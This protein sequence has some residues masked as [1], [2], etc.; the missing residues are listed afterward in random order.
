MRSLLIVLLGLVVQHGYCQSE[1]FKFFPDFETPFKTSVFPMSDGMVWCFQNQNSTT[2]EIQRRTVK[3]DFD[4]ETQWIITPDSSNFSLSYACEPAPGVMIFGGSYL[5]QDQFGPQGW[6]LVTRLDAQG[7]VIWAKRATSQTSAG[8]T[9]IYSNGEVIYA[10]YTSYSV[11]CG[12]QMYRAAV[13]AYD[14]DGN[15]LWERSFGHGGFVTNYYFQAATIADNGDLVAAIDVGGSQNTQVAGIVLTRISSQGNVSWTKHINWQND[16]TQSSV[17][18]LAESPEGDIFLGC[19][20][21]TDQSSTYPNSLWIGKFSSDGSALDQRIYSAGVDVGENISGMVAS[22]NELMVYVKRY[23]PFE[24]ETSHIELI[25]INYNT[26]SVGSTGSTLQTS[27]REDVYGEDPPQLAIAPDGS[28]FSSS[29]V[30]CAETQK[31][32]SSMFKWT[33][34]TFTDCNSFD[35]SEDYTDSV[36]TFEVLDYV[37]SEGSALTHDNAEVGFTQQEIVQALDFC[38]GCDVISSNGKMSNQNELSFYPNP[39]KDFIAVSGDVENYSIM[40]LQGR[41]VMEGQLNSAKQ[42]SMEGLSPGIFVIKL[43]Q[44]AFKLIKVN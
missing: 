23:S 36:S 10:L 15:L 40:D 30:Q 43:N 19:R 20:L 34:N 35:V 16:F 27:V 4:G 12:T 33:P 8:L 39:A 21:M 41:I 38:A 14:L 44:E 3:T 6:S 37:N 13:I 22:E 32:F 25:G 5:V 29:I 42:I 2:L 17:N 24:T 28:Y 7:N 26:L 9:G 11:F 1:F 18:G 31:S